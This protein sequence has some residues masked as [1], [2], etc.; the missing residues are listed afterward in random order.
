MTSMHKT[1]GER[2]RETDESQPLLR[3]K[4]QVSPG[5]QRAQ[6]GDPLHMIQQLAVNITKPRRRGRGFQESPELKQLRKQAVRAEPGGERRA[7]WKLERQQQIREQR[8]WKKEAMKRVA[9]Q[10]W[11]I[12]KVCGRDLT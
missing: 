9:E 12:K 10:D 8:E 11:N 7:S 1:G 2:E 4:D 3:G 5:G 6:R